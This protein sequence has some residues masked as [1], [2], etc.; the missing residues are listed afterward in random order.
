MVLDKEF[1]NS[2]V[3]I[4]KVAEVVR[5]I[6]KDDLEVAAQVLRKELLS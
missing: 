1:A 5:D 2:G 3:N 4:E 6:S